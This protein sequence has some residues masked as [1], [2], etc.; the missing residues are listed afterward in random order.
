MEGDV[1]REGEVGRT[2]DVRWL[3]SSS[4]CQ[5]HFIQ[6]FQKDYPGIDYELLMG[7]YE[8]IEEWIL[9]GRVDCGFLRLPALGNKLNMG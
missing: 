9:E 2:A 8:E 7:D 1:F 6:S 4:L 5:K 3:E